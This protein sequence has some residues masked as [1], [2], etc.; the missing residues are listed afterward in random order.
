MISISGIIL[1]LL[2]ISF[3]LFSINCFFMIN[4][5]NLNSIIFIE[6]ISKKRL[7]NFLIFNYIFSCTVFIFKA[8][9]KYITR[10]NFAKDIFFEFLEYFSLFSID[11]K[12]IIQSLK[13]NNR[14]IIL[15]YIERK[16]KR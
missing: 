9:L 8:I 6:Y 11:K 13:N 15:I 2:N 16:K 12:I 1:N 4:Q 7:L 3:I 5:K 10:K 14:Y